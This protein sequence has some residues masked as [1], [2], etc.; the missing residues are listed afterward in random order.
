MEEGRGNS[1]SSG[2]SSRLARAVSVLVPCYG[3]QG[4]GRRRGGALVPVP[5]CGAGCGGE[6]D[7]RRIYLADAAGKTE[8]RFRS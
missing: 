7:T 6:S 1:S 2:P 3:A 8:Y 5:E 4:R